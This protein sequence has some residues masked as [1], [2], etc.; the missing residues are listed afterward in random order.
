MS[1]VFRA[2]GRALADLFSLRVLWIVVWPFLAASA[3]WLALGITFWSNFARWIEQ[4]LSWAGLADWLAS[5]EPLWVAGAIQLIV[6]LI[7]FVPLVTLTALVITG[8]FAMP[9]LVKLVA[10]RDHPQLERRRGG[11]FAGSLGNAL[12]AL[13]LFVLIWVASLPLWLFGV[14]VVMPFVAAAWLNQR[15]FRYDAL[16]EHA[17]AAE[18]RALFVENRNGWW[19]LGLLTGCVQFIPLV[20][21]LAPVLAALAFTHYGLGQL[22]ERRQAAPRAASSAR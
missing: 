11:G 1:A 21:L 7:L 5:T 9:A 10:G 3:L 2:F 15:L 8:I 20:N 22:A 16:A 18:M 4:F 14:G 6:H 17:D 19:G 12:I 13:A